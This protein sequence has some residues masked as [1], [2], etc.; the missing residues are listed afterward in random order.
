[1]SG[2]RLPLRI[3]LL[4]AFAVGLA[5]AEENNPVTRAGPRHGTLLIVG[6]GAMGQKN[7]YNNQLFC[8]SC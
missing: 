6:G 3:L 7:Y 8:N 1:M 2:R 5:S 4:A